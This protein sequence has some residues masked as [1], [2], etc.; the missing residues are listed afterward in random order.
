MR[1][2][3]DTSRNRR[4]GSTMQQHKVRGSESR[5]HRAREC[6]P[7]FPVTRKFE[8]EAEAEEYV[9]GS[10][11]TCLL[12]GKPYKS[13]GCHTLRVHG[14]D[15]DHYREMYDIP[16]RVGLNCAPTKTLHKENC[17]FT[18]EPERFAYAP[19]R[20]RVRKKPIHIPTYTK[21]AIHSKLASQAIDANKKR[22][23]LATQNHP[24]KRAEFLNILRDGYRIGEALKRV[25]IDRKTYKKWRR[26]V[27][28][29]MEAV[30]SLDDAS[31][32][33]TYKLPRESVRVLTPTET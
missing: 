32:A 12:C 6:L 4:S 8:S 28:G 3:H 18:K 15:T 11:I 21:K 26:E 33:I 5:W 16:S 9:S 31:A 13:L 14:I 17:I 10:E 20:T 2:I 22:V 1:Y 24:E 23:E 27:S 7:G 29:F 25:R 30:A 19:S